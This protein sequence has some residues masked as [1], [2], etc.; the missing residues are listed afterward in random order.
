M[1][2]PDLDRASSLSS[3]VAGRQNLCRLRTDIKTGYGVQTRLLS[4][5]RTLSQHQKA[6]DFADD[7][8]TS[9]PRPFFVVKG[10]QSE[11]MISV[12]FTQFL[13]YSGQLGQV[14]PS[15]SVEVESSAVLLQFDG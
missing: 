10:V 12:F 15:D 3:V 13:E 11:L 2:N 1:P 7:D 8:V 9:R 4:M 5:H 6:L 14:H